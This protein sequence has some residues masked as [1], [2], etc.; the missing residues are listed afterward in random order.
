M[1]IAAPGSYDLQEVEDDNLIQ[2][3]NKRNMFLSRKQEL[4]Y[5]SKKHF[6]GYCSYNL[7]SKVIINSRWILRNKIYLRHH[8]TT[9][10]IHMYASYIQHIHAHVHTFILDYCPINQNTYH[11]VIIFQKFGG[12]ASQINKRE[13]GCCPRKSVSLFWLLV[14]NHELVKNLV[15]KVYIVFTLLFQTLLFYCILWTKKA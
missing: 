13:L 1:T 10:Y 7:T 8:I 6:Q 12:N 14:H 15:R 11:W 5:V 4:K 2:L 9:R 3:K